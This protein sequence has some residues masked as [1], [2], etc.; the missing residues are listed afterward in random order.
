MQHSNHLSRRSQ[1]NRWLTAVVAVFACGVGIV[2]T[3]G[4]IQL[5]KVFR[6]EISP[7]IAAY[8]A[9]LFDKVDADVTR[10]NAA[11]FLALANDTSNSPLVET[12][13]AEPV[14][15]IT[16]PAAVA[17]VYDVTADEILNGPEIAALIKA[18]SD[19]AYD[20]VVEDNADAARIALFFRQS[21]VIGKIFQA[22]VDAAIQAGDL[23]LPHATLANDAG[24]DTSMIMFDRIQTALETGGPV[25]QKAAQ[26]LRR[27]AFAASDAMTE[28]VDGKRIYV[29]RPGDS[30]PYIALQFYGNTRFYEV[31]YNTNRAV[32]GGLDQL[33]VGQQLRIPNG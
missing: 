12:P 8:N 18:V 33:Q 15:L 28:N 16:Q 14:A 10:I 23:D 20:V 32:I 26:K 6:G 31:I 1:V 5:P 13:Q 7:S 24:I 21:D 19:D 9:E 11:T 4:A 30:L 27:R 25:E 3:I 22:K 2:G 17:P 29:V